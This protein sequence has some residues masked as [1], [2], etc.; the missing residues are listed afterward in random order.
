MKNRLILLGIAICFWG[1]SFGQTEKDIKSEIK[2]VTV[3]TQ[4]A[5]VEREASIPIQKGQMILKLTGLSPYINK[6]SIRVDGDGSY[7]ILTV[8]HQND[9]LNELNKSKE[10]ES[11]RSKIEQLQSKI[12]DEEVWMKINK[13]KLD[14]LNSNKDLSSKGQTVNPETFKSLNSIYGSNIEKLNLDLL[15]RQRLIND[16]RKEINK[17]KNQLNSLNNR[18]DLPS[19]TILITVESKLTKA[20]KLKF[21]YLVDNAAWYPSFDIRFL[22]V[23]KPLNVTYKGN[24]RQNTGIDWKDV[25]LVLSTAKTNVSANIP[26]LTP[27]YLQF[28]YPE[29]ARTLKGRTPGVMLEEAEAPTAEAAISMRGISSI[30]SE[31]NP[32]YVVDGVA[33]SNISSLSP[34]EIESIK[35]LKGASATAL[36]GSKGANGV[37]V[38]TT[39]SGEDKS[40]VPLTITSKMETSNEYIID[41]PQSIKSNNKTTTVS[42]RESNLDADFEYQSIPKL[43]ENVFLIGKISD[44]HNAELIDGEVNV[45]LEN[46]Y[47]GKSH[48]DTEQ[49]KDTLE[50]SFGIDNNISIKREKLTEFSENQFIGSNRK[51]TI[52]YKLTIRNN[53]PYAVTTRVIDQIPI[54]TT[55]DIQVETLELSGGKLDTDTGKVVWDITLNP[56]EN[57]ELIIKYSVRYPKNKKV[58]VD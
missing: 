24:I 32:L 28:Y 21:N 48:I 51:E 9:Y 2:R 8:Q 7:T 57:K 18:I 4:G 1:P 19:G 47:V 49:F 15:K 20:A 50:V 13:D 25:N 54:S 53:K 40:S 12:E 46:S 10:I 11:L 42:F 44:W 33:K 26:V 43:S 29:I 6:E 14:F 27:F 31:S 41:A 56:N 30:K 35:V 23:N 22:G 55:K 38:I 34:N 36:Y 3:F 52:A 17:L 58:I 45:Y 39:K 16:Y 37:V 5:Q